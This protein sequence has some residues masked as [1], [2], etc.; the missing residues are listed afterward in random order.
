[1]WV[2]LFITHFL[3][4]V[5]STTEHHA[6]DSKSHSDVTGHHSIQQQQIYPAKTSF[7]HHHHHRAGHPPHPRA[8]CKDALACPILKKH[9]HP[10]F[11]KYKVTFPLGRPS[12][13]NIGAICRYRGH[14]KAHGDTQ[15]PNTG[16][17][18]LHRRIETIEKM[19]KGYRDCCHSPSS[20]SRLACSENVWKKELD[21]FCIMELSVKTRH[22]HCCTTALH[23][24][25]NCFQHA[26]WKHRYVD[27]TRL[28]RNRHILVGRDD[29]TMLTMSLPNVIF[30]PGEP[31]R[32]NIHNI[33]SLRKIRPRYS[34]ESLPQSS[35]SQLT[36]QAKAIDGLE[37]SYEKCCTDHNKLA[38]AH[39]QW[40]QMLLEY[41]DSKLS[42]SNSDD[43]CCWKKEDELF[44]C[45]KYIAAYPKYDHEITTINLVNVTDNALLTLCQNHLK[46]LTKRPISKL[47][48]MI[49]SDCCSHSNPKQRSDCVVE[50]K[51]S[52]FSR[53]CG[54]HYATRKNHLN[55][56]SQDTESCF[57]N[58]YLSNIT[59]AA[60][61]NF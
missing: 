6:A 20:F 39:K 24:R 9:R 23:E 17:S 33:C 30:P 19:E 35:Y 12:T 56:C 43:Q 8:G 2:C 51:R 31:N 5:S 57:N 45:F 47:L 54:S 14:K 34:S 50:K 16:F 36:R 3:L 48:T 10:H 1:M 32:E 29:A 18:F 37:A 58:L 53:I 40:K 22:Y 55:C 28:G 38:C 44:T 11:G 27:D 7:R 15:P 46:L 25:Y 4:L 41:C 21:M 52:F 59:V 42:S 61:Y 49:R 13:A 60:R 26:A